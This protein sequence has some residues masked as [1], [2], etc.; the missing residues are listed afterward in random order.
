VGALLTVAGVGAITLNV[1]G[2]R[3]PARI[4]NVELRTTDDEVVFR[5]EPTLRF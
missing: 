5:R 1:L 3:F 4:D 2:E